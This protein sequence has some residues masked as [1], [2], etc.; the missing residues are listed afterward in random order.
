MKRVFVYFIIFLLSCVANAQNK[1]TRAKIKQMLQNSKEV[2]EAVKDTTIEVESI[3]TISINRSGHIVVNGCFRN[4]FPDLSEKFSSNKQ[5]VQEEIEEAWK[6][7]PSYVLLQWDKKCPN[8]VLEFVVDQISAYIERCLPRRIAFDRSTIGIH[9]TKDDYFSSII[10]SYE[11]DHFNLPWLQSL[12]SPEVIPVVIPESLTIVEDSVDL[13]IVEDS[14]EDIYET[15]TEKHDT[16]LLR[17]SV[18]EKAYLADYYGDEFNNKG[19]QFLR[20]NDLD[21]AQVYYDAAFVAYDCIEDMIERK[22]HLLYPMANFALVAQYKHQADAE[23]K[24]LNTLELITEIEDC[25]ENGTARRAW[26]EREIGHYYGFYAENRQ[27]KK[28]FKYLDLA[29]KHY[30]TAAKKNKAELQGLENSLWYKAKLY[31]TIGEKKKA[32]K[33]YKKEIEILNQLIET[34]KN[35][36]VNKANVEA[37]IKE[38]SQKK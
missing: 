32:I 10:T 5:K 7:N 25:V 11:Y 24:W 36:E 8:N 16:T 28:A 21:N 27:Y 2:W 4:P 38:L 29:I 15:F 37:T 17:S 33:V 22:S 18:T 13:T 19:N 20:N 14:V 6:L 23:E 34:D 12:V 30:E 35:W 9:I 1:S 3:A 31:E 26:T